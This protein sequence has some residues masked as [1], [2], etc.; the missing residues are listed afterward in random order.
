MLLQ[1]SS[2]CCSIVQPALDPGDQG[3]QTVPARRRGRRCQA[4]GGGA[5]TNRVEQI[6]TIVRCHRRIAH[7]GDSQ[8]PAHTSRR[9]RAESAGGAPSAAPRLN[10]VLVF[11]VLAVFA[12]HCARSKE[13]SIY[14]N[15]PRALA[16]ARTKLKTGFC[17][18]Y[19]FGV[20]IDTRRLLASCQAHASPQSGPE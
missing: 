10:R 16:S 19:F 6:I 14:S 9:T 3:H 2:A 11:V 1:S 8:Q 18:E 13:H 7:K 20:I 5:P 4:P 17:V 15:D 12:L